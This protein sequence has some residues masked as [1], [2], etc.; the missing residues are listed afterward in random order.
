MRR[1]LNAVGTSVLQQTPRWLPPLSVLCGETV[2]N[3]TQRQLMMP[4]AQSVDLL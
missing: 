2:R 3:V 1:S 4:R